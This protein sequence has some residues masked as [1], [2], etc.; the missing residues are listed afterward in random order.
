MTAAGCGIG[1]PRFFLYVRRTVWTHLDVHHRHISRA[2]IAG[3]EYFSHPA[4]AIFLSVCSERYVPPMPRHIVCSEP[5]MVQEICAYSSH[6][7]HPTVLGKHI[8]R[9]GMRVHIWSTFGRTDRQNGRGISVPETEF[10]PCYL[11]H[12]V[13]RLMRASS[14]VGTSFR[15]FRPLC[16][17][18][19]PVSLRLKG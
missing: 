4:I 11:P 1:V 14:P 12:H 8:R 10:C 19:V 17:D 16:L 18:P 3:C 9:C 6:I 2:A 7:Y 5:A 13:H 15:C